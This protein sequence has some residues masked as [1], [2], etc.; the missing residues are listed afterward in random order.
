MSDAPV[1]RARGDPG[2]IVTPGDDELA[3][4]LV[5]AEVIAVHERHRRLS[6]AGRSV[7]GGVKGIVV[8]T[9]TDLPVPKVARWH[10]DIALEL[11]ELVGGRSRRMKFAPSGNDV[12]QLALVLRG[13]ADDRLGADRRREATPTADRGRCGRVERGGCWSR[14][15]ELRPRIWRRSLPRQALPGRHTGAY[16]RV[17]W[18]SQLSSSPCSA[19]WLEPLHSRGRLRASAQRRSYQG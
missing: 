16:G 5:P 10:V 15:L 7:D 11:P 19:R 9:Y 6:S 1:A 8:R 4:G 2:V 3:H 18:T 13:T 12:A 17:P 14:E